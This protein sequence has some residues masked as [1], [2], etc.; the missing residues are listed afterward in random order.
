MLA[1]LVLCFLKQQAKFEKGSD[2]SSGALPTWRRLKHLMYLFVN[3]ISE[4]IHIS[5]DNKL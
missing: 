1:L 3:P 4:C 2:V 5:F